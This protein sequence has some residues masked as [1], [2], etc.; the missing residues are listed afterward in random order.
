V[1]EK[2]RFYL[3]KAGEQATARYANEEAIAYFTRAL[4]M[5]PETDVE[6]RFELLMLR[7]KLYS[8]AMNRETQLQDLEDLSVLVSQ[9]GNA[10]Q[11]IAFLLAKAGYFEQVGKYN[12]ALELIEE[13]RKIAI[14]LEDQ[15]QYAHIQKAIGFIYWKKGSFKEALKESELAL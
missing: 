13:A 9:M 15:S 2:A 1:D 10:K 3:Q 11:R 6:K 12:E 8:L 4:E 5:T 7:E 14:L